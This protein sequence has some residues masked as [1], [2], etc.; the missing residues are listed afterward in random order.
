[1]LSEVQRRKFEAFFRTLDN[2]GDGSLEWADFDSIVYLMQTLQ[3]GL[4]VQRGAGQYAPD[5]AEWERFIERLL[6]AIAHPTD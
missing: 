4:L 6:R 5:E 3:L 2:N 1:M